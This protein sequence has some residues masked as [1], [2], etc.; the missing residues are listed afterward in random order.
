MRRSHT[1]KRWLSG[2]S[3][4][5]GTAVLVACGSGGGD[6]GRTAGIE[7]TGIVSGF[8][9][10][11]VDGIEFETTN[12][13][14]LFVGDIV[15]ESALSVGDI[16]S[17][18]GT[19]DNDDRASA[20]RIVFERTLDG[21]VES[22]EMNGARGELVALEQTVR[23]DEDTTFVNLSADA[24]NPG[25]LIAVSGFVIDS[26]LFH[27]ESI[28]RNDD[29]FVPNGSRLEIEGD[30]DTVDGTQLTVGNQ[31][32]RFDNA[33]VSP[34]QTALL[35][36]QAIEAFGLRG[37]DR[38][39]P[40]I[41]DE[42]NVLDVKSTDDG[43]RMFVEA[44]V[45]D[46]DG[47]DDFVAGGWRIDARD[48]ERLDD[49]TTPLARGVKISVRGVFTG[50][51]VEAETL[52]IDPPS[53]ATYE[54]DIEAVDTQAGTITLFD[55]TIILPQ[56]ARYIDR[57]ATRDENL[58]ID[59]LAPNDPVRVQAYGT[60]EA[61]VARSL[62]RLASDA[63]NDAAVTGAITTIDNDRMTLELAGVT[64]RADTNTTYYDANGNT[65]D[66]A[67][68]FS[69]ATTGSRAKVIGT[70]NVGEISSAQTARLLREETD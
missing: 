23:F 12:A 59:T 10:V 65:I 47:V 4:T 44:A 50:D 2:F 28:R 52:R 54:A 63:G 17:V 66:A 3:I 39:D 6:D 57:R 37:A 40:L 9:S 69:R 14:I 1:A 53:D 30:I 41:A 70:Q 45:R 58:R 64:A 46:Y 5:L 68:F 26:N 35:A 43:R 22:I 25:D 62:E 67:A 13:E 51:R 48:A 42:I 29:G 49:G 24:L 15:D 33:R 60:A 31:L 56:D 19:V 36:G 61:P 20:R 16:V 21:P 55:R 38:G 8:G 34:N 18:S 27:A 32:I 7:G 11:Y